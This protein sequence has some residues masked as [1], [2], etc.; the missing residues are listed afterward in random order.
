M[1]QLHFQAKALLCLLYLA[2]LHRVPGTV[3]YSHACPSK[4][5]DSTSTA[6]L[7]TLRELK[8]SGINKPN[9]LPVGRKEILIE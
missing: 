1:D 3:Y 6:L 5:T 8:E 4:D 9:K 2:G 7:Q